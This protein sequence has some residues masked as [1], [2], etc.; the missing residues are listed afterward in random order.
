ME[1][2]REKSTIEAPVAASAE[3]I[4]P[5]KNADDDESPGSRYASPDEE[6]KAI[7]EAKTGERITIEV[8]DA[9][10]SNLLTSE[11]SKSDF[12]EEVKKHA[13][14]QWRN[15]PGFLRSLSVRYRAKIRVVGAPVT[16]AEAAEK[17]YQC[18]ICFSCTRGE[19]MV[20]GGNGKP[21][22]CTCASPEYIAHK[23]ASGFFTEET[24]Q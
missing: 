20:V 21:A 19:G 14:N 10:R 11:V 7:Y 9:I 8:M 6:L 1:R 4:S 18:P 15:P 5:E 3:P 24:P 12:V 22:P 16:A 2:V 23:R 13:Q 17:A